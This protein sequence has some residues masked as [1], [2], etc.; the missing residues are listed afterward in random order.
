MIIDFLGYV[1]SK[2]ESFIVDAKT[3]TP[4]DC[5][6]VYILPHGALADTNTSI[7]NESC[8]LTVQATYARQLGA[9]VL[10]FKNS[11]EGVDDI[12][13]FFQLLEEYQ[14][15]IDKY[16]NNKLKLP[17][18]VIILS[19]G[20]L[21]LLHLASE[22]SIVPNLVTF[23]ENTND[24]DSNGNGKSAKEPI[25]DSTTL[26]ILLFGG[27]LILISIIISVSVVFTR[28]CISKR[29]RSLVRARESNL[30]NDLNSPRSFSSPRQQLEELRKNALTSLATINYRQPIVD[31]NVEKNNNLINCSSCAICLMAFETGEKLRVLPCQHSFHA[32][33]IDIWLVKKGTCPYCTMNFVTE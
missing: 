23:D 6:G 15:P 10:F 19:S 9:K 27:S 30:S 4:L 33:E 29:K 26:K 14:P 3:V 12:K 1:A 21:D 18:M 31:D 11:Y 22:I 24:T 20:Y 5:E 25:L 28:V 13:R 32:E 2:S 7:S 16:N 8:N 17:F